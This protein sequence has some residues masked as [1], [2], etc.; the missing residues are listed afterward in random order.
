M[1]LLSIAIS[2]NSCANRIRIGCGCSQPS[3][4]YIV[5]SE[6][7][8][9]TELETGEVKHSA[10]ELCS[11]SWKMKKSIW[12]IY[13]LWT[14]V[15]SKKIPLWLLSISLHGNWKPRF[16]QGPKESI[17][18]QLWAQ[19]LHPPPKK[20]QKKTHPHT[21]P[22]LGEIPEY[23]F[24]FRLQT[25]EDKNQ[26]SWFATMSIIPRCI[27]VGQTKEKKLFLLWASPRNPSPHSD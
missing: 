4:L 10:S 9:R 24:G 6:C 13:Q 19:L 2:P 20:T 27:E 26:G 22:C 21:K 15:G 5:Y 23:G 12:G 17:S 25:A 11:L 16:S 7:S 18:L 8:C 1:K 3:K 14:V